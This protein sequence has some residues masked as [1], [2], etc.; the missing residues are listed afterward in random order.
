MATIC[1]TIWSSTLF[2]GKLQPW[3][4][5]MQSPELPQRNLSPTVLD[6]LA[7]QPSSRTFSDR[8][9]GLALDPRLEKKILAAS[10]AD[11]VRDSNC[12][13]PNPGLSNVEERELAGEML[14]QR[15]L[16]TEQ[17]LTTANFRQATLT[18]LQ[19]IYL[20]RNRRIFFLAQEGG[21]D[22]ERQEALA[23]FSA[24]PP[25]RSLPLAKTL[26]HPL[27]ARIWNR[28]VSLQ[29]KADDIRPQ[30]LKLQHIVEN[31]NTLRNIYMLC[32]RRLVQVLGTRSRLAYLN[33]TKEDAAQIG[34]FGVAR[35]AYRYHPSCGV[36]F[37]T[38]ASNWIYREIQLQALNGKLIRVSSNNIEGYARAV[39]SGDSELQE[40]FG[41]RL[42]AAESITLQAQEEEAE[43]VMEPAAT[44]LSPESLCEQ[45]QL[46]TLLLDCIDRL[47]DFKK[48][49]VLKRRFG[50]PPYQGR[51]ESVITIARALGVTRSS[52]YQQ[53]E[54]ALQVLH[55]YLRNHL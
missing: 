32:S 52:V 30:F 31:L 27:I 15:H 1:D 40:K 39:R 36:R 17:L 38:Y 54:T 25:Q 43:T 49:D 10:D 21:P 41:A 48:G 50:L 9:R 16:F 44:G 18:I 3:A 33:L 4:H 5:Y 22:H 26:Q 6:L 2:H 53:E 55:D 12:V 29:E 7:T 13:G 42:A 24:C 51:E 37:S 28:I 34:A 45:R 11:G 19:N 35:A 47:L 20:F 8:V 46:R 14:R 23:L